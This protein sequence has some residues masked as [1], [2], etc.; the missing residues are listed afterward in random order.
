MAEAMDK[1]CVHLLGYVLDDVVIW[2]GEVE[3]M[4]FRML[5]KWLQLQG[6]AMAAVYVME[7]PR[8]Q[9]EKENLRI[10]FSSID[11]IRKKM[12]FGTPNP[13]SFHSMH[14]KR[15]YFLQ[16]VN[17]SQVWGCWLYY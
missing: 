16:N 13:N 4:Q 9:Q 14:S 10:S 11:S 17:T 1:L 2:C 5:Q 3:V 15:E 12:G 7:T 6:T 8:K